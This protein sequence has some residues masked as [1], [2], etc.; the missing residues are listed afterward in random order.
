MALFGFL[1]PTQDWPVMAGPAPDLDGPTLQIPALPFGQ[2]LDAARALGRQEHVEWHSRM[3]KDCDLL[4]ASKGL[5]LE[6]APQRMQLFSGTDLEFG[7]APIGPTHERRRPAF[8]LE[9]K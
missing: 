3:T 7:P 8:S 2:A 6:R 5:R 1:N 9:R 4:Y